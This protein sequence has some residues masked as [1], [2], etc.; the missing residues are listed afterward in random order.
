MEAQAQAVQNETPIPKQPKLSTK[1]AVNFAE[2][3]V[4]QLRTLKDGLSGV[5]KESKQFEKLGSLHKQLFYSTMTMFSNP[6]SLSMLNIAG[7]KYSKPVAVPGKKGKELVEFY[8]FT[9]N[10]VIP[11]TNNSITV[12]K[13]WRVEDF[14]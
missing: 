2:L 9:F 8:K 7:E 3:S 6:V 11:G 4:S 14:R 13:E 5:F 12:E 10:F 1:S